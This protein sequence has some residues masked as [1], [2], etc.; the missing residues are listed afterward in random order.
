[1]TPVLVG[2]CRTCPTFFFTEASA[3]ASL[4]A[5]Q[6]GQCQGLTHLQPAR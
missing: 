1:M 5:G 2:R 6:A 4:Q 3:D